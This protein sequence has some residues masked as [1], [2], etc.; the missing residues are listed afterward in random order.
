MHKRGRSPKPPL[1][2]PP[3]AVPLPLPDPAED[4]VIGHWLPVKDRQ[5][6]QQGVAHQAP[7]TCSYPGSFE[8]S[9]WGEEESN[10]D[11]DRSSNGWSDQRS[12]S[13]EIG[14]WNGNA[15]DLSHLKEIPIFIV[16]VD[17]SISEKS[18]DILTWIQHRYGKK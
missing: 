2:P 16:K 1:P 8:I 15:L 10:Q 4:Y 11:T 17:A 13:P 18:T 3:P 6:L 9:T 5:Q 12:K 14:V 7:P